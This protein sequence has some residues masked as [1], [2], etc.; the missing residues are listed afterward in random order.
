MEIEQSKE[1]FD[2]K[3]IDTMSQW[4]FLDIIVRLNQQILVNL[5]SR[6]SQHIYLSH[7]N[8]H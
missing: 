1:T 6:F 5:I 2:A 4:M 3:I 8:R 7:P